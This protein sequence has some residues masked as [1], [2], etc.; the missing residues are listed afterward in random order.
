EKLGSAS[1]LIFPR[2][3]TIYQIPSFYTLVKAT[4]RTIDATIVSDGSTH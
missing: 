1:T 3:N 2:S 4:G